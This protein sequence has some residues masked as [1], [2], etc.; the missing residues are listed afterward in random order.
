MPDSV[1]V[2]P[3]IGENWKPCIYCCLPVTLHC[4]GICNICTTIEESRFRERENKKRKT[5]PMVSATATAVTSTADAPAG[6]EIVGPIENGPVNKK[7]KLSLPPSIPK[8]ANGVFETDED[9]YAY[10]RENRERRWKFRGSFVVVADPKVSKNDRIDTVFGA[11]RKKARVSFK[12]KNKIDCSSWAE[13]GRGF[14]FSY[15]RVDHVA[16]HKSSSF[17]P[18]QVQASA[19]IHQTDQGAT[20]SSPMPSGSSEPPQV[21][22]IG[23]GKPC[24]YCCLPVL[25]SGSA[26]NS[27]AAIEK[28]RFA[29]R[30]KENKKRKASTITRDDPVHGC[31]SDSTM[32]DASV[33]TQRPKSK[34]GAS[35]HVSKKVRLSITP[36][37]DGVY[38]TDQDL[39]AYLRSKKAHRRQFSGTY[40]VVGPKMEYYDRINSVFEALKENACVS[41]STNIRS[42]VHRENG[43]T[44]GHM[45]TCK[46]TYCDGWV[47]VTVDDVQDRQHSDPNSAKQKITVEIRH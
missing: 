8:P 36:P 44:L 47:H 27:C 24:I 39:Y 6:T 33:Q 26:C 40:Y 30:K 20:S 42:S 38:A 2:L 21:A 4:D 22:E 18:S 23:L 43:S 37:V 17:Y 7:P 1:S 9:L 5:S 25:D 13:N 19:G 31:A 15:A 10:I 35:G 32:K 14:R 46:K 3:R 12:R 29:E 28:A 11:L 16:S 41:F 34:L 45:C